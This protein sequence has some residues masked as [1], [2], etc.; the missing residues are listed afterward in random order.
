[1]VPA[2][3]L[4]LVS[5]AKYRELTSKQIKQNALIAARAIGSEQDRVLENAHEF[6]VTLSRVPQIR[7][8]DRA[9][10]SKILAGLLE[11]RYADL[12]VA[13]RNGNPLCSALAPGKALANSRGR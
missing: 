7:D 5:A 4:I 3:A 10:C 2:F 9:A 1:M 8:N 11:P 12:V 13:D 6:L